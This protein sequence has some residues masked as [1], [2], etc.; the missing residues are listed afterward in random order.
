EVAE[1]RLAKS[2]DIDRRHA[3]DDGLDATL[4]GE[5]IAQILFHLRLPERARA[6]LPLLDSSPGAPRTWPWCRAVARPVG[7]EHRSHIV[8]LT[9]GPWQQGIGPR[10]H[11]RSTGPLPGGRAVPHC[12]GD[13]LQ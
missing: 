1:R 6:V 13:R 7:V 12:P 4:V 8:R 2:G 11:P 5:V 9:I 3:P 10:S